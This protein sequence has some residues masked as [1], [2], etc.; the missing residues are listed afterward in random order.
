MSTDSIPPTN[1]T[2]KLSKKAQACL[3]QA[4]EVPGAPLYHMGNIAVFN[5]KASLDLLQD[6]INYLTC[7]AKIKMKFSED[8]KE[9]LIELYESLWWGGYAKGMPEAAKLAS[10]YIKGKGKSASMGP[11]PYQQSVVVNDT[12]QA[13]K[14]Y[15]KELAGRQEYFFNL[16]TNDPKF[17]QSPHFKPLMLINGSRNIDTQGYVESVGRIFAEQFNQRL[18]KADHRFYLEASTQKF[19]KESFHTFWSVNNRYDFEPFAKGDK[20]TNLPLSNSKTLLLPDGLSEYMD[21][22]LD[23]AK[24]FNYQAEWTEIW[25]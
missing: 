2:H 1:N 9:F 15:I 7:K 21:S 25:K 4:V 24:P 22:G 12:I 6:T 13:M 23:L 10:H 18:Q 20:I 16:K 8:E 14:L 17:R 5:S 11:Q 3:A 19:T